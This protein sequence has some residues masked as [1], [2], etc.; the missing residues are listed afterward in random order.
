VEEG[1]DSGGWS[2]DKA[3]TFRAL[4]FSL[5]GSRD[6]ATNSTELGGAPVTE[7]GEDD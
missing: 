5:V 3:V 2:F 7:V 1:G 6:F 4:L